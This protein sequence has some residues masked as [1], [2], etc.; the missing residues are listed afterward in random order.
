[1]QNQL[2][3]KSIQLLDFALVKVRTNLIIAYIQFVTLANAEFKKLIIGG[4]KAY[5]HNNRFSYTFACFL[6][7]LLLHFCKV[8]SAL[9][10]LL[11]IDKNFVQKFRV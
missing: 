4:I 6:T 11:H 5:L 10:K 7:C 2:K 9:N 1:M 3:V 8:I